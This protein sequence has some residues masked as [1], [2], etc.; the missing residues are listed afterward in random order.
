MRILLFIWLCFSVSFAKGQELAAKVQL[1]PAGSFMVKS[2]VIEGAVKK[3]NNGG[4]SAEK[5]LIP[6]KTL[7]TGISLRDSHMLDRLKANEFPNIEVLNA[8]GMG[9]K[10]SAEIAIKGIKKS[11]KGHYKQKGNSL[12]VEF[13]IK[14]SD[15]SI[16]D[17]RYLGVGV[18]DKVIIKA[19]LPLR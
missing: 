2:K 19:Q 3:E 8:K 17:V 10:G 13:P 5:I 6:V 18:K 15:F 11:I 16:T 14:L 7:K 4:F 1:S 12:M 9:G